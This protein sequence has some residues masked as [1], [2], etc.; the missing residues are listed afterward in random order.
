MYKVLFGCVVNKM[1]A[2]QNKSSLIIQAFCVTW[3]RRF[4]SLLAYITCFGVPLLAIIC[5]GLLSLGVARYFVKLYDGKALEQ[6]VLFEDIRSPKRSLK[7]LVQYWLNTYIW[8]MIPIV[9]IVLCIQKRYEYRFLPHLMADDD[10]RDAR[11]LLEE[12]SRMSEGFRLKMFC[13]DLA[14][15]IAVLLPI[16]PILLFML[17]PSV[18]FAIVVLIILYVV[19]VWTV[20]PVVREYIFVGLFSEILQNNIKPAPK[21]VCCPFCN[22]RMDSSCSY[23]SACGEKL[24]PQ[25]SK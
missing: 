6:G 21:S 3:K 13:L 4:L 20:L 9:G 22:S 10:K 8:L 14:L 15:T 7:I 25:G 16:I 5:D 19:S 1:K 2:L 12:S 24:K 11:T 23:C 17:I 18:K